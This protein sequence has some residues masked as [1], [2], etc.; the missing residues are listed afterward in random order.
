MDKNLFVC[1]VNGCTKKF[2]RNCELTR[3]KLNHQVDFWP[4]C[5]AYSNC[6]KKFKRKDVFKNHHRTHEKNGDRFVGH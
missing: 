3:H 6:G 1:D 2:G 4:Y 5:C